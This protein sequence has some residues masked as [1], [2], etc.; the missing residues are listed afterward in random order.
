MKP[1]F[2]LRIFERASSPSW[3]TSMPSSS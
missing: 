1:I 2:W 3:L